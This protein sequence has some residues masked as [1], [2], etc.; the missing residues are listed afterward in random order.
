MKSRV[1]LYFG[2]FNPMHIGHLALANYLTEYSDFEEL[3]F[4]P[5]PLNPLK[6]SQ[7]I[8]SY[9]L[10]C[11][12]VDKS[13][14][15]DDRFSVE[16]LECILPQPHY[17]VRTL[18]ALSMLYPQKQFVLLIGAD[19]WNSFER[20]YEHDRIVA[21]WPICIYPRRGYKI[22]ASSLPANCEYIAD[23]PCID[24]SSTTIRNSMRQGLD[25]RYWLPNPESFDQ[26]KK[27]LLDRT[28]K[29]TFTN[30]K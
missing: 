17:T 22:D 3:C 24:V 1:A 9:E 7:D 5:S 27:E 19:N 14:E 11:N 15:A 29:S 21:N 6:D 13:V 20:W 28:L 8:L 10:R 16:R 25:L 18:R 30:E 23:A 2:S 26:I 4:V 12:I